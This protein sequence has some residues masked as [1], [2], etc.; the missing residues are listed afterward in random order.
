MI[1]SQFF[2]F[3]S[4]LRNFRIMFIRLVHFHLF[5]LNFRRP[6]MDSL[7][8]S[9]IFRKFDC[10]PMDFADFSHDSHGLGSDGQNNM[11]HRFNTKV[12]T[13]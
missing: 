3:A 5:W 4:I 2:E 10:I 7:K 9:F 6:L 1:L 13:E 8:G 12:E 11:T